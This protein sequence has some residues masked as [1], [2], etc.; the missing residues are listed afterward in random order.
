MGG[1]AL[2][3]KSGI[4]SQRLTR[5]EFDR[6]LSEIHSILDG[7]G[8]KWLDV[9]FVREKQ[10]FG[11][12]DI[13]IIDERSPDERKWNNV[14]P[15]VK[16]SENIEKFGITT[17]LFVNNNP[18]GSI[19]YE[20]RYQVDFIAT[21]P[22]YAEYNQLYLS[23]NDLGNLIGR[24]VKRFNMTHGHDGLFYDHY[25]KNKTRRTRILLSQD[26]NTVLKILEL[27]VQKFKDGFDT[28]EDMFDFVMSSKYFDPKIFLPENLNNRNRV[29]DRK[30][31]I[32]NMF[33][34]YIDQSVASEEVYDPL[35]DYPW[36]KHAIE[37]EDREFAIT[38]GIRLSVPG[39]LVM[40]RTGLTGKNLGFLI[41]KIKEAYGEK[42]IGLSEEDLLE[43]IDLQYAAHKKEL[44]D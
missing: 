9:A 15:I 5:P 43:K 17:D 2:L 14:S 7:L 24:Q 32:Y 41:Y 3:E 35:I 38:N 44:I 6:V 30:R 4:E 39:H 26:Y 27:D 29:R 21:E 40:N 34:Q 10:D 12:I 36:V 25:S 11:D 37:G 42:L 8:I 13:L 16:I 19:L 22:S 33:L 20:G 23:H 1:T 28:Y 18:F 31:K